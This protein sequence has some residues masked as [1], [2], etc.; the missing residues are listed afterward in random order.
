M[1]ISTFL[2]RVLRTEHDN[3]HHPSKKPR[4][5]SLSHPSCSSAG[6]HVYFCLDTTVLSG[7]FQLR[8]FLKKEK[9][10]NQSFSWAVQEKNPYS[11]S[12]LRE[13]QNMLIK[14]IVPYWFSLYCKYI[15]TAEEMLFTEIR[16]LVTAH[17]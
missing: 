13:V 14:A 12:S 9:A 8:S 1:Q 10:K 11:S 2:H 7:Y 6:T 5:P 16:K 3:N 15:K 4:Y 17:L